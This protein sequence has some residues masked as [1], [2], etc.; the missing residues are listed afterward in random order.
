MARRAC[1]ALHRQA[2]AAA[3]YKLDL[4]LAGV[5]DPGP[6]VEHDVK[7]HEKPADEVLRCAG[8]R[9]RRRQ[10]T[11]GQ[12][13]ADGALC[14][15]QMLRRQPPMAAAVS[16]PQNEVL[17]ETPPRVAFALRTTAAGHRERST[18]SALKLMK[19]GTRNATYSAVLKIILRRERIAEG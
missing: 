5:E 7:G 15:R 18:W 1:G 4:A 11:L 10:E 8:G 6:E 2:A 17:R 12:L 13:P 3:S 16:P 14:C 19:M 9:A